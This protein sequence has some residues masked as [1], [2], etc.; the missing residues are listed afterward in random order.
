MTLPFLPTVYGRALHSE[1]L[2][3]A[4]DIFFMCSQLRSMA[5]IGAQQNFEDDR[6]HYYLS[7][8]VVLTGMNMNSGFVW[9]LFLVQKGYSEKA[10]S[11]L[12]FLS[13]NEANI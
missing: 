12:P 10:H 5:Y 1:L 3:D 13:V 6:N 7:S 2:K 4:D 8:G 9:E 11:P